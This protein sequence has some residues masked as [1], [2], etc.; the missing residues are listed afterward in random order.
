MLFNKRILK[1]T[2]SHKILILIVLAAVIAQSIF[3]AA[4][5]IQ[6]QIGFPLDDAWI[7]QTYARNLAHTFKWE[8]IPG[9]VSGGSTSPLWTILLVPGHF[10][11]N[12]FY[13]VWTFV[14]SNL[15]FVCSAIFFEKIIRFNKNYS[16][17]YPIAGILFCFEWHIAWVTSSGME[18]ILY[19]FLFLLFIHAL[20]KKEPGFS[21]SLVIISI[22]VWV[23]P[24]GLTL[25]GPWTLMVLFNL[26]KNK[27][28][29]KS[30]IPALIFF[31]LS[32]SLYIG[33]NHLITGSLF[34]NTFYAK[35][36]EYAVYYETT[37]LSRIVKMMV[38]PITGVGVL[39]IPGFIY[40][41]IVCFRKM[42]IR[43]IGMVF[44]FFGYLSIYA[45]KLPVTYQHGR[46]IIPTIPIFL[47]ISLYGY[48]NINKNVSI[49][50]PKTIN[51]AWKIAMCL[52]LF[53]FFYLGFDI[54]ATDVAIIESEMVKT[55]KWINLNTNRE[56]VIGAHD[57]GALGFFGDRKIIDLAGL[58]TPDVI[59]FIRDEE[60]LSIYLDENNV[61]LLMTFPGWYS[62]LTY[63]KEKIFTTGSTFSPLNGGENMTIYNWRD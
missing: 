52:I 55:S 39:L 37:F 22:L 61:D 19:I 36:A 4:S 38:I 9:L 26:L 28:S 53:I 51:K 40:Q 21:K 49:P 16:S 10:F 24:D 44:W 57:I 20:L 27:F 14:L 45:A 30:L 25:L 7:H 54:Y 3:I 60:K 50:I 43:W 2:S 34:P 56:I 62:E 31:L 32:I 29:F 8:Y 11:R 1:F 48:F 6:Y 58:I 17:K 18:T 47:I 35:Q 63:N 33:F 12:E 41:I 42:E 5:S 23:R 46:Y 15:I 13:L 59:P